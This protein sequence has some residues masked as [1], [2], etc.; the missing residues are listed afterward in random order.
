[1][2]IESLKSFIQQVLDEISNAII[3]NTGRGY[4]VDISINNSFNCNSKNDICINLICGNDGKIDG[5]KESSFMPFTMHI[6]AERN[7]N[8]KYA[9]DVFDKFFS[10]YSMKSITIIDGDETYSCFLNF[11]NAQFISSEQCEN[12]YRAKF[13][14]VGSC[15]FSTE[16]EVG[17]I[18]YIAFP[19]SST[20]D[21]NVN[22]YEIDPITPNNSLSHN[23]EPQ[24]VAGG[25]MVI[26]GIKGRSGTIH[27]VFKNDEVS[28]KLMNCI[29]G[30]EN[31]DYIWIKTVFTH[32]AYV[33]K[34]LRVDQIEE[35]YDDTSRHTI[36]TIAYRKDDINGI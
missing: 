30:D 25:L 3:D 22:W 29:Y 28:E 10:I 17:R 8:G 19:T 1:M 35:T 6:W 14:M 36:L 12:G 16:N 13:T 26:P 34:K 15:I 2:F 7:T 31:I 18:T 9:K 27:L 11:N 33:N 24:Q 5:A 4:K 21:S 20:T 32:Y 23:N